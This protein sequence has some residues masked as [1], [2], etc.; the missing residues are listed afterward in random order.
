VAEGVPADIIEPF[1]R[2]AGA[3]FAVLLRITRGQ[4]RR[5]ERKA[6]RYA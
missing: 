5:G 3:P 4:F 6:F 2:Q 1:L